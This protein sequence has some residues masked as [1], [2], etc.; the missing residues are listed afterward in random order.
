MLFHALNR[1]TESF[2]FTWFT[3]CNAP[4]ASDMLLTPLIIETS[5]PAQDLRDF[6]RAQ[7]LRIYPMLGRNR[8]S[9]IP[10][11]W[12]L[13]E[14]APIPEMEF[15]RE[16]R[17]FLESRDQTMGFSLP[18]NSIDGQRLVFSLSG[19]RGALTQAEINELCILLLYAATAY[20]GIRR[21][22]NEPL[23]MLSAREME[24]VRWTAQGKTSVEIGQILTLSD[25]TVNAYMTNAIKKLNCVNRTQL[26]AKAIRLKLIS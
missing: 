24:V 8:D 18:V 22:I 25:H 3:L 1:T 13:K 26:V 9:V 4:S 15:P 23:A 14:K 6:D 21:N 7:L 2:D 10:R 11:C 12:S 16:L 19:N 17:T 5:T 20:N